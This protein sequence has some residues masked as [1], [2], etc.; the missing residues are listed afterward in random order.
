[1]KKHFFLFLTL[2]LT[3]L[4]SFSQVATHQAYATSVTTGVQNFGGE[5]GMV[6]RVN[7]PITINSLGAFDDKGNGITGAVSGGIRVAIFNKATKAIVPGLDAIVTGQ[8]DGYSLGYRFKAIAP[9]NLPLGEYVIVAKGY[10]QNELNGNSGMGSPNVYGDLSNGAIAYVSGSLY[11][12]NLSG[13][14]FPTNGDGTKT[15][16]AGTFSYSIQQPTLKDTLNAMTLRADSLEKRIKLMERQTL[17]FGSGFDIK[18]T[19]TSTIV[20]LKIIK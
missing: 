16:L 1:M 3:A 2:G 9:V 5:L 7:T 17:I 12:T 19:D 20:N 14:N 15:Y 8:G 13:F 10:N 4:K 6:F 18:Q 11:G